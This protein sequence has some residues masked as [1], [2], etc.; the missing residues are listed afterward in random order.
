MVM[1]PLD[2]TVGDFDGELHRTGERDRGT[3]TLSLNDGDI[4]TYQSGTGTNALVFSYFTGIGSYT[5]DLAVTGFDLN[6]AKVT[7]GTGAAANLSG[8]VTNPAGTLMMDLITP[9]VTSMAVT[10]QGITNN[11]GDLNAGHVLTLT[12]NMSTMVTL[13]TAPSAT[14]I[15]LND[16]GNFV[17]TG[18]SGPTNVLTFTY[19]VAAGQNT[20]ALAAAGAYGQFIDAYGNQFSLPF[21]SFPGLIIDTTAPSA[22]AITSDTVNA[23][24][25]VLHGTAEANSTVKVFDGLTTLGTTAAGLTGAWT[26]TT[27][28]LLPGAHAFTA[29][30]TDAAGNVGALAS[31]LSLNIGGATG[32]AITAITETPPTGDLDAGKTVTVTVN[33]SKV[34]NVSGT[35]TLTL[36]DNGGVATYNSGSGTNALTF[37][38]TVGAG[39][40]TPA[41]SVTSVNLLGGAMIADS[42]GNAAPLTLAGLTET[43]PQIDTTAPN[44]PV[45]SSDTV[46][47]GNSVTLT[48]T[49]TAN[50]MV[51]LYNGSASLG[52]VTATS[53]GNWTYTTAAFPNGT[54]QLDATTTDAAG[55]VSTP[56]L[57]VVISIGPT[58][59]YV[60]SVAA[61][62]AGITSGSGD[63]DAGHV[64]TLTLAF[65]GTVN[66]TGTPSLNLNDGGTAVYTSGSGSNT[67]IFTYTV[68]SAQNSSG[69]AITSVNMPSGATITDG[70]G[71][72]VTLGGALATFPNLQIDTTAPLTPVIAGVSVNT[73]NIAMLSGT[74]EANSVVTVLDNGTPLGS[75]QAGSS[76][77]WIY[78]STALA[79][80]V[81]TLTVTATDAAGNVSN[82]SS[83]EKLTIGT[84]SIWSIMASGT[85][86][87]N[88]NG[89]I[90]Q[91]SW[92]T[93]TV[94]FTGPVNV[95]GG[96]PTLSLNDG[97]Q[98]TYQSGTGTSA[99][100]FTYFTG[101]GNYTPDLT[102]TGF[103]L[104]GSSVK[105]TAGTAADLSGAVTNPVGTLLIDSITPTV[106][107][108]TMTVN[109][110]ATNQG[111]LKAGAVVTLTFDT[112]TMVTEV[113]TPSIG[114][115][116]GGQFVYT[117]G[118]GPTNVITLSYT[119]AAGQNTSALAATSVAG[120]FVDSYG[121]QL[122]TLPFP[123]LSGIIIDT[124]APES[125]GDCERHR[126]RQ[127]FGD[128]QR[129]GGS[130]KHGDGL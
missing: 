119:V 7:D 117:G 62:G 83:P 113:S 82:A 20:S 66:V 37:I 24:V 77:S 100:V 87:T 18:I 122:G 10:G 52:T 73:S 80:G 29:N 50:S 110:I 44:A 108:A 121:N 75:V 93:L 42:S 46:N 11:T 8:A 129:H 74:A 19:T 85:G 68:N 101:I 78:S 35:P 31:S 16:G 120:Q 81:Q 30:A 2:K 9:T 69:L 70:S 57:P 94:N 55:N 118:T 38:Y 76:G 102:V 22:P 45:I 32:P 67:L 41:L 54:Y 48:G 86:I 53:A 27:A 98:A 107:S 97:D 126:Q 109:G 112:S 58:T 124:T 51:T 95:T 49:A 114:L 26:F 88:G 3:P 128:A 84:A 125:A 6:G 106:T 115:N 14:Y 1:V 34:V 92:V 17:Y 96:T 28:T 15:P 36:N 79:N 59:P 111:D 56:S 39:Q 40:N 116:D 90:G 89:A 105:N 91:N 25:V 43:G 65:S 63:L 60:V 103:N 123:S 4:A 13:N 71:N 21:V 61:T 130:Q 99:L 64:V 72:S 5:P 104:N 33:F 47:A 127:Q 12:L 23:N